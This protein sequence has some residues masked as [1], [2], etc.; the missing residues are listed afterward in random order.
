MSV[1]EHGVEH[2]CLE[3]PQAGDAA[4]AAVGQ[5]PAVLQANVGG[6]NLTSLAGNSARWIERHDLA[7]AWRSQI[8]DSETLVWRRPDTLQDQPGR[9]LMKECT[10][11]HL[12]LARPIR[13]T[14]DLAIPGKMT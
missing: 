1:P 4:E 9:A 6:R 11:D 12:G 2:P 10:G 3:E 8:H 5:R 7:L 14:E 13:P